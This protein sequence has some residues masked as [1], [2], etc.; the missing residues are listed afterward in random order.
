VI[1]RVFRILALVLALVSGAVA[2]LTLTGAG[3]RWLI[4]QLAA[5]SDGRL[6][7]SVVQG[8]LAGG[9]TIG[10]VA[11]AFEES[12]T[13]LGGVDVAVQPAALLAGQVVLTRAI[14]SELR[15]D[16]LRPIDPDDPFEMPRIDMPLP[17]HVRALTLRTLEVRRREPL[18]QASDLSLDA[19]WYG[20]R[21]E[22]ERLAGRVAGLSVDIRGE[23]ALRPGLP[24]DVTARWSWP[25]PALQGEG[26]VDGG[27]ASLRFEQVVKMPE[28]VRVEGRLDDFARAPR[29]HATVRAARIAR[30]VPG[31]RELAAGDLELEVAGWLEEWTATASSR[32]EIPGQPPLQGELRLA[33]DRGMARIT[34]AT[35]SGTPG[36]VSA[37][38]DWRFRSEPLLDLAI[39]ADG[40]DTGL[41]RPE[42]RGRVSAGAQL[43]VARNGN[44][45][46]EISQ[47][48][49][50]LM[51]RNLAGS[52]SV[53]YDAGTWRF[54]RVDLRAGANRLQADGSIG[55]VWSGRFAVTAPRLDLLWPGLEGALEAKASFTRAKADTTGSVIARANDL[56]FDGMRLGTLALDARGSLAQQAIA[57]RAAGGAADVQVD[58]TGRWTG[59]ALELLIARATVAESRLG[60]WRL[61]AA[62]T[63][64]VSADRVTVAAHCWQREPARLCLDDAGIA[65]GSISGGGRL[66]RFPL[67]ALGRYLPAGV[68]L[69]GEAQARFAF[70]GSDGVPAG[71][72]EA[73]L[74]GAVIRYDDAEESLE[75]PLTAA[76]ATLSVTADGATVVA[77]VAG[78]GGL[79]INLSGTMAP[80]LGADGALDLRINGSLPDITP[81]VPFIASGFDLAEA[82]GALSLDAAIGGTAA[83][84]QLTGTARLSGGRL[85]LAQY[86]VEVEGID[87]SLIGDGSETLRLQGS[88]RAGG[89]LRLAGEANPLAP[90]GASAWF[91]VSGNRLRA[92][93]RQDLRL[94]VSPDITVRYADRR[95]TASGH[96]QVP[97]AHV[98]VRE[99][100][101]TAVAVSPDVVVRDRDVAA[102]ADAAA[103]AVGGDIELE[104]G[105]DVHLEGFGLDTRVQGKVRIATDADDQLLGFGTLQ[106]KEGRFGAYGSELTI[107]R[108]TLGFNGALDDP[109][110][111]VIASRQIEWEGRYVKAGIRLRGTASRPESR[112]YAEPAMAEADALSYLI[113]GR[114]LQSASE[115]DRASVAGA[116][117][118]LGASQ[119]A[120]FTRRLGGAVALDELTVVG[121]SLE[122]S[123]LVAG[124]RVGSD[125]YLRL[126][127]GVFNRVSTVLARYRIG[128]RVSVEASSGEQQSLDLVYTVERD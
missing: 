44:F 10:R 11:L 45:R 62:T 60:E 40:V 74:A 78:G 36:R 69:S 116:A 57:L 80:P 24:V 7:V 5:R 41:L 110:L 20:T 35:V 15:I 119:A 127:Y 27:L 54:E 82:G 55:V 48:A 52:G 99:L 16:L 8:T 22:I 86:G 118:A 23:V 103:A 100:P 1:R 59:A 46:A 25:S 111:N 88:A 56:A 50:T 47:L 94:L 106:L 113:S 107:E 43:R 63:G 101:E 98:V 21:V 29:L 18:W 81:I 39:A 12:R 53:A 79:R 95:F 115:A 93:D 71:S 33:G 75:L 70:S 28:A 66:E 65:A 90:G 14:V 9:L 128:R 61:E 126:S 38:G 3:A 73:A 26:S 122:E 76:R 117:L 120:P 4:A 87:V 109:A 42:L 108:G 91:R 13:T 89:L 31:L 2:W 68:T 96:V 30:P 34:Q 6:E 37:T 64:V 51:D 102:V 85:L 124:K 17:L 19:R 114:P 58:A 97:Q 32:L 104:L 49:G 84:P 77:E 105:R 121:S 72:L 67:A 92:V 83:T 123:Q 112:V 125:L